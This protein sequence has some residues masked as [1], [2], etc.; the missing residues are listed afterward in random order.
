MLHHFTRELVTGELGRGGGHES[1][2][3]DAVGLDSAVSYTFAE[4]IC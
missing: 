3:T 4:A 1:P 2:E